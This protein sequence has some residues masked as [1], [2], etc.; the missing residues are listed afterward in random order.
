MLTM[1][2]RVAADIFRLDGS[3]LAGKN[4]MAPTNSHLGNPMPSSRDIS[5]SLAVIAVLQLV[6]FNETA[7][8]ETRWLT[9]PDVDRAL[10]VS[11][12]ITWRQNPLREGLR[13]LSAKTGV[14]IFLDRRLDPGQAIDLE[15]TNVRLDAALQELVKSQQAAITRVGSVLYIGPREMAAELAQAA[16]RRRQEIG[17]LPGPQRA[18]LSAVQPVSWAELAEPRQL[19]EQLAQEVGLKVANFDAIPHDLWPAFSSPP[20]SWCDRLTLVLAG[21]HLTFEV[22]SAQSNLII[23]P[24]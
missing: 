12:T 4:E 23:K 17:N 21:F 3:Q 6:S 2:P 19:V 22:D 24:M 7:A 13:R 16:S 5:W 18:M 20:L 15:Q 1:I 14:G 11:V 8:Q 9:G 10:K